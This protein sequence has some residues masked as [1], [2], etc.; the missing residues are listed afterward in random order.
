VRLDLTGPAGRL[1]ALLE[2]P[3][4]PRFAALVLHPHPLHGG[5]MHNHATYQIARAA[6]TAGGTT[7]RFHFRGVGLSAGRHDFGPGELEDARAALAWL[8]PRYPGLPLLAAGMSFGAFIALQLAVSEEAVRGALGAG[9]ASRA[10]EMGFVRDCPKRVAVVQGDQDEFGSVDEVR[11]MMEGPADRRHLAILPGVS[12]LFL[13][14]LPGLQRE[15]AAAWSWL[16]EG[17][18]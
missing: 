12:H 10:F 6:R 14:D 3:A 7:L 5:T 13:E 15:A 9:V 17:L 1:E 2:E 8:G 11:A 4:E 18:A 16:A